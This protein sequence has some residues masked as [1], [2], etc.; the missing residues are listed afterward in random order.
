M[1]PKPKPHRFSQ[2]RHF[3]ISFRTSGGIP[4]RTTTLNEQRKSYTLISAVKKIDGKKFVN[5]QNREEKPNIG[6]DHCW[7]EAQIGSNQDDPNNH[8]RKVAI[9]AIRTKMDGR[10][11]EN[12]KAMTRTKVMRA[13]DML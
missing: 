13:I 1:Q 12:K 7:G 2:N 11:K 3:Q 4:L 8:R 6:T 9:L 10:K 5:N